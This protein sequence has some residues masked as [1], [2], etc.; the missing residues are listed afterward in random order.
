ME[1]TIQKLQG[2][3]IYL[4]GMMGTGKTTLGQVLA[5]AIHYRF[6]DTDQIIEQA[7]G[8]SVSAIFAQ[9]GEAAFRQLEHQVLDH[10]APYTH[11]VIAT[12]GGIVT[13][14]LNWSY[15]REGLVVWL[16]APVD[17]LIDRLAADQTRPLL[18]DRHLADRLTQ[19][20]AD[21]QELYAQADLKITIERGE[22]PE[23]IVAR[24]LAALPPLLKTPQ[25]T[26]PVPGDKKP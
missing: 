20:L 1:A 13:Q 19:L 3:N 21:R 25:K 23:A 14:P 15:L 12:G 17:L 16:D 8:R 5:K 4:I 10:L 18:Q 9:E 22:A 24:F 7:A 2:L 11:T 26:A 6:L